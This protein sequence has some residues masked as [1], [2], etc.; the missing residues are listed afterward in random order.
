MEKRRTEGS[1]KVLGKSVVFS[2]FYADFCLCSKSVIITTLSDCIAL[3]Y[4][5]IFKMGTP[6]K[7]QTYNLNYRTFWP[8]DSFLHLLFLNIRIQFT[9]QIYATAIF[10]EIDLD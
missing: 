9:V 2:V 5:N 4:P 1:C 7:T 3:R 6:D 10:S 8:A